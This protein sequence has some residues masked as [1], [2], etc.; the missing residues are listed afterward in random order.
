MLFRAL[1]PLNTPTVVAHQKRRALQFTNSA[2]TDNVSA[3]WKTVSSPCG[4]I[5][6][7]LLASA[8][9]GFALPGL[10]LQHSQVDSQADSPSFS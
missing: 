8:E 1:K 3:D 6:T 2:L 10:Q 4:Q 5:M 9:R 7:R